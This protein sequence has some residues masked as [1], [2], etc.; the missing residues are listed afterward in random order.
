MKLRQ[1][2]IDVIKHIGKE[3]RRSDD[4]YQVGGEVVQERHEEEAVELHCYRTREVHSPWPE[5]D[6]MGEMR[7]ERWVCVRGEANEEGG[8]REDEKV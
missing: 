4:S 2:V 8:R 6:R 3:E 7:D 5:G 1:L